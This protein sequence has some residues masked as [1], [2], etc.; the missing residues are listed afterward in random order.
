MWS[1]TIRCVFINFCGSS[2]GSCSVLA[3]SLARSGPKLISIGRRKSLVLYGASLTGK[4]AWAR[5]LGSHIYCIG[6]VSGTECLKAPDVDYAVFDDIRGGIKFFPSFKEWLGCQEYVTVK[7]L[8]REPKLVKW[9]KVS[10]W[11]ANKDPRH[12]MDVEDVHW[13]EAN[14]KFVEINS[15]I[16]RANTE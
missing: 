2:C 3:Y 15:P 8:Y 4:S 7:Q 12:E 10:I 9:G 11:L 6:L 16:F 5:S 13:L 1:P 14:C